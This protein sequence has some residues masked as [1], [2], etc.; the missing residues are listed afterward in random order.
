MN[1]GYGLSF[2]EKAFEITRDNTI[3]LYDTLSE[4]YTDVRIVFSGRGFH[5][6]VFDRA[7]IPLA[8]EE[9]KL[10]A[11]RYRAFGIDEWVTAGEMRLIR[12]PY[13]LNGTASRIVT[14]LQKQELAEFNPQTQALPPFL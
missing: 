1:K 13:T 10:I 7:T 11:Y 2:C 12:L 6:H 3:Q 8:Q 14:P 9:R 4:N 5:L